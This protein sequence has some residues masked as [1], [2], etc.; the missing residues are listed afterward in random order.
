MNRRVTN[1]ACI[2][3]KGFHIFAGSPC[4]LAFSTD[5]YRTSNMS[6]YTVSHKM[7]YARGT[8]NRMPSRYYKFSSPHID[9]YVYMYNLQLCF[10]YSYT[11]RWCFWNPGRP[12]EMI[13][14]WI[15]YIPARNKT[16]IS[17]Y[18]TGFKRVFVLFFIPFLYYLCSG[19]WR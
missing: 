19:E 16:A 11:K 6:L 1:I 3:W 14:Y 7:V 13:S 8:K 5:V 15:N 18:V 9:T 12:K 4:G 2:A 10:H 17:T